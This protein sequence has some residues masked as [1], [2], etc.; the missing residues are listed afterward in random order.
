MAGGKLSKS[1][2]VALAVLHNLVT[3]SIDPQFNAK[4]RQYFCAQAVP[5]VGMESVVAIS[6]DPRSVVLPGL[7]ARHRLLA[8]M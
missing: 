6:A 2:A 3:E 7:S 4:R 5:G 1:A 8:C